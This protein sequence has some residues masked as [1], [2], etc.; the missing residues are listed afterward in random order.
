[1][2]NIS[3]LIFFINQFILGGTYL[4]SGTP[5][6][7]TYHVTVACSSYFEIAWL[8][9]AQSANETLTVSIYNSPGWTY[10]DDV[11]IIDTSTSQELISNGGFE[12]GTASWNGTA[13]AWISQTGG[14]RT[15][16]WCYYDGSSISHSIVQTVSTTIGH[17]LSVSLY[18][19]WTGTGTGVYNY[20]TINP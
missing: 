4:S 13:L 16:S 12:N 19:Q 15:G 18:I 7:S 5:I 2:E 3:V 20:I 17:T 9:V 14:C 10:V 8:Y 1:M 11:S 6:F